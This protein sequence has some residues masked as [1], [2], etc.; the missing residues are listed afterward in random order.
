MYSLPPI[1]EWVLT[2]FIFSVMIYLHLRAGDDFQ[3]SFLVTCITNWALSFFLSA[4]SQ[5]A[6]MNRTGLTSHRLQVCACACQSW[7]SNTFFPVSFF[8]KP[9]PFCYF[10]TMNI[11]KIQAY[12]RTPWRKKTLFCLRAFLL[13][14][15]IPIRS[16][17]WSA[18]FFCRVA[19]SV[20]YP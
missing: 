20:V 8:F 15:L 10:S 5:L 1:S 9:F 13:K 7:P 11:T 4:V 17:C 3:W 19:M 16:F 6:S 2:F 12:V 14:P 18:L